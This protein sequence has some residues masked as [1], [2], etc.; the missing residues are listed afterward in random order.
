MKRTLFWILILLTAFA[1]GVA[2]AFGWFNRP[3]LANEK[4]KTILSPQEFH[5]SME[6]PILAYCELANNP[7]KY[8]HKIVRV[9]A[10]LW[11]MMHGYSFLN[12]NCDGET[13]QTAVILPDGERGL[14]IEN[15]IAKDIGLTEYNP[16]SFPEII[17]VGKF[18]RVEPSR[19]SDSMEDNTYLHFEILEIEKASKY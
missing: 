19:K 2:T 6:Q 4:S 15:K 17:A 18:S 16:W 8:D 7:E 13:K 10:R 3:K 1:L 5:S 11:F 9:S 12:K 14:E